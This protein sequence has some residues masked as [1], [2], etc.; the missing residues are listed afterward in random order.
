M[1]INLK[2]S[3]P[4]FPVVCSHPATPNSGDPV[5]VGSLA[6]VALTDEGD[7][8]NVATETTVDFRNQVWSLNVDDNGG[9]G[10]ALGDILYYHDAQTGTP[11]TSVN[12]S[13]ASADA[14]FGIAFGTLGAN[15]TGTIDVLLRGVS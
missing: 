7:G 12:N 6:G 3:H 4:V 14:V 13:A 9:G 5:R 8:G 2:R 11:A 1:A 15:A 10:I